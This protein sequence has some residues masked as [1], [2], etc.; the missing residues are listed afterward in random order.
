MISN[1]ARVVSGFLFGMFVLGISA[2]RLAGGGNTDPQPRAEFRLRKL[3]IRVPQEMANQGKEPSGAEKAIDVYKISGWL[4]IGDVSDITPGEARRFPNGP[5]ALF[6]RIGS[7]LKAYENQSLRE[8]MNLYTVDSR[9]SIERSLKNDE[10]KQA[11][12]E[13]VARVTSM[14]PL[15]IWEHGGDKFLCMALARFQL[16]DHAE[17]RVLTLLFNKEFDLVAGKADSDL[18]T[19][20]DWYFVQQNWKITDILVNYEY[21]K[22]ALV[23]SD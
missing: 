14:R 16:G 13:S 12:L 17:E 10:A 18:S 9:E 3:W 4:N 20:L 19:R 7:L 15:I 23:D 22:E 2:A 8:V 1:R 21:L 11:W 5:S 6:E